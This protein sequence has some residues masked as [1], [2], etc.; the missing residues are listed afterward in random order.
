[1]REE[2]KILYSAIYQIHCEIKVQVILQ[3]I[4]CIPAQNTAG[5]PAGFLFVRAGLLF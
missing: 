1:M 5:I 2:L 3:L 4:L